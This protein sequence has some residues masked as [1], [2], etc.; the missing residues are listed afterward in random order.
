[1]T[2]ESSKARSRISPQRKADLQDKPTKD[3]ASPP[4]SSKRFSKS[5]RTTS[6]K[7]ELPQFGSID[8]SSF[9][10]S[11]RGVYLCISLLFL[12]GL[13]YV[14]T[15][16]PPSQIANILL[17]QLY[18]PVL[19]LFGGAM[20]TLSFAFLQQHRRAVFITIYLTLLLLLHFQSVTFTPMVLGIP[21]MIFAVTELIMS[22]VFR[23]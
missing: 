23:Q 14:F 21:L 7:L 9:I 11:G 1:M 18:P 10:F 8:L 15:T 3:H 5:K 12:L 13:L 22:L 2:E 17:Y 4:E 20:Y 16:I 6:S 19:L